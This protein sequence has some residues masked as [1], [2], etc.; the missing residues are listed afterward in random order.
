MKYWSIIHEQINVYLMINFDSSF[1]YE[2]FF[3]LQNKRFCEDEAMLIFIAMM[4]TDRNFR[5][6]ISSHHSEYKTYIRVHVSH[7]II[8]DK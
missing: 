1:I 5:L 8:F 3:F 6:N 7:I 4:W 2:Y